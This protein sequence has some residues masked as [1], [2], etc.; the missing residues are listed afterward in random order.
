L[1]K[2]KRHITALSAFGGPKDAFALLL[3]QASSTSFEQP[4]TYRI[5]AAI[6]ISNVMWHNTPQ[7]VRIALGRGPVEPAALQI[8]GQYGKTITHNLLQSL[9]FC[10]LYCF[11]RDTL[12]WSENYY[13]VGYDRPSPE[14]DNTVSR[15]E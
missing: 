15:M 8:V 13:D 12:G 5:R 14:T 10:I 3:Q 4:S 7:L 11:N 6:Q 1:A 9:A 2:D